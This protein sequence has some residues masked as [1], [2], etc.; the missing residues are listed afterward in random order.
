MARVGRPASYVSRWRFLVEIDG[1]A[2]AGF[3]KAGPLEAEVKPVEVWEGGALS[4]IK[5]PAKVTFGDITLERG[6][7]SDRDLYRWFVDVADAVLN[8]GLTDPLYK[9]T[10]DIVQL[11]RAGTEV[12]RWRVVGAWPTKVKF[13]EWDSAADEVLVE[14]VTLACDEWH[15]AVGRLT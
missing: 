12:Q 1:F 2:R 13:G 4:P 15:L 6:A 11:D 7:T 3:M 10:L 14:S 9:R 5:L 8:A